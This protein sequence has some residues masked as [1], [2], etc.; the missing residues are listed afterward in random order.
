MIAYP[1]NLPVGPDLAQRADRRAMWELLSL[2]M[3][4]DG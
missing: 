4:A 2:A 1:R 3:I